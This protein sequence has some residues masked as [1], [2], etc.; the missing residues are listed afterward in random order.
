MG[1]DSGNA[2]ARLTQLDAMRG[3]AALFVLLFHVDRTFGGL[4]MFG[5]AYLAVDF[6]FLLSGFVLTS[7]VEGRRVAPLSFLALRLRRL[8]PVMAIGVALGVLTQSLWHDVAGPLAG[9]LVAALLFVP[10]PRAGQA[11][12]PLNSVE[13]SLFFELAGNAAHVLVLR[14]LATRW[15]VCIAAVA[16]I[17]LLSQSCV[18]GS[19]DI[20]AKAP[21]WEL[22]ALRLAFA[23]TLGGAMGRHRV[24]LPRLA[25]MPWWIPL[26][27][28]TLL[29][30][31]PSYRNV[32][33][34]VPDPLIVLAF[35]PVLALSIH[36][37]P[38][39]AARK[40]LRAAGGASWPLYAVHMPILLAA[41]HASAG[42]S[43][44]V[45]GMCAMLATGTALLL[46]CALDRQPA[47]TPRLRRASRPLA[48]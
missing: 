24:W 6:F 39:A 8:W 48:I 2:P 27:A 18:I 38:P 35:V 7:Q 15:L 28:L 34:G 10:V 45:R 31:G 44:I 3:I 23:Y 30:L 9:L 36:A 40:L 26:V 12:F 16:W 5:H 13:W 22:G 43:P 4:P 41:G 21:G 33:G 1:D 11:I 47:L 17:A 32:W 29:L 14:H 20:G 19:L 42:S 25:A 46:A 37:E